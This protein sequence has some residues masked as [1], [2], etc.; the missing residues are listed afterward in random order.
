M[1]VSLYLLYD[2]SC[3]QEIRNNCFVWNGSCCLVSQCV[4]SL[5]W[6][7]ELFVD[8]QERGDV[9][10]SVAIVW[11]RPNSNEV[12]VF[13]PE[14]VAVHDKLMSTGDQVDV[15]D[16]VEFGRD[17][18]SEQ[19]SSTSRRHSPS[20]NV[21]RIGPHEVAE[22]S[23]VWNLHSSV[24]KSHL[25]DGLELWWESAVDAENLS[26][27]NSADSKV[28]ED[29][30]AVLPR[31]GVSI[32]SNGLIV[33]TIDGRDL[34]SLVISSEQSDVWWVLHLQAEK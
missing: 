10:T 7:F 21:L 28:I 33:E 19:P 29:F 6:V 23:F 13:E 34:P 9:T 16:V 25:I 31:V 3:S 27:D 5:E 14:L 20:L 1:S 15:V 30:S 11:S 8:V 4:E 18:G 2:A 12:L 24:D 17:L 32:L 26:F 22:W